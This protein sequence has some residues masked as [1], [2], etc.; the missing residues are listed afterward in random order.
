MGL[1]NRSNIRF[2]LFIHF[3]N[4]LKSDKLIKKTDGMFVIFAKFIQ[5]EYHF[6][7]QC[8]LDIEFTYFLSHLLFFL[9][10]NNML[11]PKIYHYYIFYYFAWELKPDPLTKKKTNYLMY[12]FIIK[13]RNNGKYYHRKN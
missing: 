11:S 4:S 10:A 3:L 13:C 7:T 12:D 5:C 6:S 2:H 1:T 8:H 9:S